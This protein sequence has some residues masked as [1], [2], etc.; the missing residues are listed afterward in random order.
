MAEGRPLLQFLLN[1]DEFDYSQVDFS[2]YMWQNFARHE[3]FM[4]YFNAHKDAIVPKIVGRIHLNNASE[5]EKR[6][7][8]GFLL[9][10]NEIWTV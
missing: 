10:G 4:R 6:I 7:L 3:Q 8:Y 9:D 2:N 5:A 1:P